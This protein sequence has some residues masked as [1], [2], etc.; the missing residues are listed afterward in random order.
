MNFNLAKS[1]YKRYALTM[2]TITEIERAVEHLSPEE[3]Q[4]FRT[5]FAERD[6]ADWD[7]QFDADVAA[8][9]LDA[10]AEQAIREL[11]AGRCTDL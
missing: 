2:T 1:R 3:L 5:W 10:L 9:K 4:A 8:G 11:R 6:A 7:Q